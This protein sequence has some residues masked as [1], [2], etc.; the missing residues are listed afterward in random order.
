MRCPLSAGRFIIESVW[1]GWVDGGRREVRPLMWVGKVQVTTGVVWGK[2]YV[3]G[4]SSP[5]RSV[6]DLYFT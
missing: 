5:T 4:V 1:G 6:L 3:Y 2:A